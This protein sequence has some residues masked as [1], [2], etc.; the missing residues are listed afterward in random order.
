MDTD[1][2][3]FAAQLVDVEGAARATTVPNRR[4]RASAI[5]KLWSSSP[6]LRRSPATTP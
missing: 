4:H 1:Q 2:I 3:Q 5:V 6:P